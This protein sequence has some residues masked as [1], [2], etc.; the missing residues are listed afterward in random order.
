MCV[1]PNKTMQLYPTFWTVALPTGIGF[2][3]LPRSYSVVLRN[4]VET[5]EWEWDAGLI[6]I[7]WGVIN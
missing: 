6:I 5:K 2:T 4:T 1:R 7:V 3:V